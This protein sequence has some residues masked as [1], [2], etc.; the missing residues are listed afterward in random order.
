[1]PSAAS[2]FRSNLVI[3]LVALGIILLLGNLSPLGLG[4]LLSTL[5]VWWPMLLIVLGMVT[6]LRGASARFNRALFFVAMGAVLQV[7]MLGWFPADIQRW[8]PLFALVFGL[9]LLVVQ[10][11]NAVRLASLTSATFRYRAFLQGSRVSIL[12]PSFVEG[13]VHARLAMVECDFSSA[14]ASKFPLS[15]SLQLLG[16]SIC[17]E[18]PE[19][20]RIASDVNI[21]L[22]TLRDER[23]VG[24]PPLLPDTPELHVSGSVL[25]GSVI[26]RD[27]QRHTQD[28]V[29]EK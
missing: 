6:L 15:L 18:I 26:I 10:P 29:E 19:T 23:D 20:W 16:G 7:M 11:K 5:L 28:E 1:M 25:L 21:T 27:A 2:R 14:T 3:V 12:T 13:S 17:L 8:W 24:N 4:S 22:G 9:W